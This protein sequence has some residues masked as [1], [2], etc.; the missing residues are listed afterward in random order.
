MTLL[1]L[2]EV[3]E[4]F[5]EGEAYGTAWGQFESVLEIDGL[6][7]A[8]LDGVAAW[9]AVAIVGG[10]VSPWLTS[11]SSTSPGSFLL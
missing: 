8:V 4:L 1:A 11:D 3:R 6:E 2:H 9:G 10:M 7:V 5:V